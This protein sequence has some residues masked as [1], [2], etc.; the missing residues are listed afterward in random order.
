VE[1][2]TKRVHPAREAVIKVIRL[3]VLPIREVNQIMVK[4]PVESLRSPNKKRRIN[5]LTEIVAQAEKN[6][7]Y[8]LPKPSMIGWLCLFLK[9]Q[10]KL[11]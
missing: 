5:L 7:S 3:S 9:N 1:I 6:N 2:I 11:L 4:K 10:K 8:R